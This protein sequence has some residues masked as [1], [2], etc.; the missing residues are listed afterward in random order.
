MV[1]LFPSQSLQFLT[2][3][4]LE[5][6]ICN[7][8]FEITPGEFSSHFAKPYL[9][10]SSY[11]KNA[12]LS[13]YI[14]EQTHAHQTNATDTGDSKQDK[15]SVVS[16]SP[17]FG[18]PQN[19]TWTQCLFWNP[20]L[21]HGCIMSLDTSSHAKTDLFFVRLPLEENRLLS[22]RVTIRIHPIIFSV[23][24]TFNLPRPS[25]V[26]LQA[27]TSQTWVSTSTLS[28][29]K[30]NAISLGTYIHILCYKL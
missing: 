23:S 10:T 26:Y 4:I 1:V 30:H 8:R 25:T 11:Q 21:I 18:L 15:T 13:L 3:L 6:T 2:R 27:T 19:T 29:I 9:R 16:S 24:S 7:S 14:A 17:A 20:S 22:L 28:F 5:L 12:L